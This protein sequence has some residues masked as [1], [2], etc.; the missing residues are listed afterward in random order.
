MV[1]Y[2]LKLL[3][4]FSETIIKCVWLQFARMEV[5]FNLKQTFQVSCLFLGKIARSRLWFVLP[6]R[7]LLNFLPLMF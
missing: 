5:D 1:Q 2:R 7:K 4:Q 3:D 6:L